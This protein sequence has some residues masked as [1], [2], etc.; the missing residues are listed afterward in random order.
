[1]CGGYYGH[2]DRIFFLLLLC[3][4]WRTSDRP[5]IVGGVVRVCQQIVEVEGHRLGERRGGTGARCG[6]GVDTGARCGSRHQPYSLQDRGGAEAYRPNRAG[7]GIPPE[8]RWSVAGQPHLLLLRLR[9]QRRVSLPQWHLLVALATMASR[10]SANRR[11]KA[12]CCCLLPRPGDSNRRL[13]TSHSQSNGWRLLET[14][15]RRFSWAGG[16]GPTSFECLRIQ[17]RGTYHQLPTSVANRPGPSVLCSGR[18]G[19]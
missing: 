4:C 6:L 7:A 19:D 3:I 2:T 16:R 12:V 5:F 11:S 14:T 13:W 18:L 8:L 17:H 15:S 1:M 9:E 10:L